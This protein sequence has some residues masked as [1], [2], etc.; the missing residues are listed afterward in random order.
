MLDTVEHELTTRIDR[1]Y[2]LG[3]PVGTPN[4]GNPACYLTAEQVDEFGGMY[5]PD[6]AYDSWRQL[7]TL[8]LAR[9]QASAKK[10][11][12]IAAWL[13]TIGQAAP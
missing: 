7:R 9:R 4:A 2:G 3:D 6:P 1:G 8:V 11:D 5:H 13:A 10:H 12:A